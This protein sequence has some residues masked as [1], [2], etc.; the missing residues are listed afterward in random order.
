MKYA[1]EGSLRKY[2][3]NITKCDWYFKLWLL[4]NILTGPDIIHQSGLVHCDL[5]DG[6]ILI[7]HYISIQIQSDLV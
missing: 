4:N 3:P 7:H 6:N 1:N 2:L 5:H